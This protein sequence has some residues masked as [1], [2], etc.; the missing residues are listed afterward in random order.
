MD[1]FKKQTVIFVFLLLLGNKICEGNR[2]RHGVIGHLL[3]RLRNLESTVEHLQKE[4]N[5]LK[6]RYL[7]LSV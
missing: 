3:K 1:C 6:G 4:N 2:F 5:D 7:E